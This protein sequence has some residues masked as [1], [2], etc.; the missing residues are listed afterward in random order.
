MQNRYY[1]SDDTTFGSKDEAYVVGFSIGSVATSEK[2][3]KS[4]FRCVSDLP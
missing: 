4:Y 1:W 2:S 3:N